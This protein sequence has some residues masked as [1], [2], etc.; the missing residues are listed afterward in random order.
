MSDLRGR[1]LTFGPFELSIGGR[2]LTNGAATIP[3]TTRG[4]R[5]AVLTQF[6]PYLAIHTSIDTAPAANSI[7]YT[8]AK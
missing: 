2:R 5:T 1:V 4:A 7:G 8:G 6:L 3:P